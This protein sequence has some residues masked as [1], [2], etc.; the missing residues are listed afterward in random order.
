MYFILKSKELAFK[1]CLHTLKTIMQSSETYKLECIGEFPEGITRLSENGETKLQ[2]KIHS[3]SEEKDLKFFSFNRVDLTE[4]KREKLI[5]PL[6]RLI[7]KESNNLSLQFAYL[8]VDENSKELKTKMG[9]LSRGQMFSEIKWEYSISGKKTN[10]REEYMDEILNIW[11]TLIK[12]ETFRLVF[13]EDLE[14]GNMLYSYI[15][16]KWKKDKEIDVIV[17][18]KSSGRRTLISDLNQ[19]HKLANSLDIQTLQKIIKSSE[20]AYYNEFEDPSVILND[21]VYDY[22]KEIYRLKVYEAKGSFP[23]SENGMGHVPKPVGRLLKLPVWMG[24]MDKVNHGTG[25]L[26]NWVVKFSGPYI[27]TVKMDGAS[28]LYFVEDGK[29]KL[30][31]RGKG[32]EGQDISELLQYLKLPL[33]DSGV[34]IRGELIIK[35]SVF[36]SK[37]K[38]TSETQEKGRYKNSRNAVGGLVNTLGARAGGSKNSDKPLDVSFVDDVEFIVYEMITVPSV[39]PNVQFKYLDQKF[40]KNVVPHVEA[41]RLDESQLSSMFDNCLKMMDYEIDGLVIYD[42]HAHSRPYGENPEYARAYKKPLE[43]LTGITQVVMVEWDVSKDKYIKPVVIVNSIEVEG[44]TISR[45]TGY[46]AKFIVDG[47]IGPGAIVEIT[48]A[49]GVIPK[50][51]NVIQPASNGQLPDNFVY[52]WNDTEVDII[53]SDDDEN[54]NAQMTVEVKRIH[55]F[56]D[57]IGTKGIG[58]TTVEKMYNL[59]F[60]KIPYLYL[61]KE[62]HLQSLGPKIAENIVATI[63][64][65]MI[66]IPLP[67]LCAGSGVFGRNM[68][69]RRF[70][71]LFNAYPTILLSNEVI[72]DKIDILTEAICR[73]DGFADI[74]SRQIAEGF[75]PF[76]KFMLEMEQVGYKCNYVHQIAAPKQISTGHPLTGKSVLLTGFRDE[77][78]KNFIESV[79]GKVQN[80]MSSATNL[81]IIKDESCINNKTKAAQTKGVEIITKQEFISK[82]MT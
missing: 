47:K 65:H 9:T 26:Q 8:W 3:G 45:V 30:Y 14:F 77:A 72:T 15:S 49:G 56:L 34:M 46:N 48:R 55:F 61:V 78:I 82:Y 29:H 80:S 58:E 33:L 79:G 76:L 16:S 50:I 74:T 24:S 64:K 2:Y 5:P 22:V 1:D 67:I 63:R 39:A 28:A 4:E 53:L 40:G 54:V 25:E 52:H 19:N 57:S 81:L 17:Q 20:E 51:I 62:E 12:D 60:K 59:G 66:N 71:A 42:D 75:K 31:S 73:I 7:G 38:K 43:I 36:N 37:Y 23:V 13:P 6:V 41:V 27:I 44:V 21:K 18:Q 70:E 35:K 68:G 11:A 32:G 10:S 69:V